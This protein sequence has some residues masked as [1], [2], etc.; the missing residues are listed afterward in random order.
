MSFKV[1]VI[2]P[3]KE[4]D[5]AVKN[6]D[7]FSAFATAVSYFEHYGAETIRKRSASL[8]IPNYKDTIPNMSVHSIAFTLRLLSAIDKDTYEKI[9]TVIAERNKLIHPERGGVGYRYS[10]EAQSAAKLLEDAKACIH[11]LREAME[12]E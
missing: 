9:K 11:K 1:I 10:I 12:K 6:G 7:W 2:N 3:D 4:I 8:E 5:D